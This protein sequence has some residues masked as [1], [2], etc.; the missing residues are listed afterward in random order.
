LTRAA[1]FG[2]LFAA[3]MAPMRT[4][5]SLLAV[6]AV[7]ALLP[8]AFADG[9]V[10]R[11]DLKLR[12]TSSGTILVDSRGYTLYAFTKD[13]R[14]HDACA[15]IPNCLRVWPALTVKGKPLAGPGVK[16]SLIGTIK[17]HGQ[18]QVTYAGHPLY[19]YIADRSPGQTYY[20]N[21]L[22]FGGRWPAVNA[23]GHEVK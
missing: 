3:V 4:V 13:R 16:R 6:V 2:T 22:Q 9:N 17:V 18:R 11:P 14:N 19:L 20:I 23:A 21:I 7:A 15:R 5:S 1:V 12:K 10:R 8:A